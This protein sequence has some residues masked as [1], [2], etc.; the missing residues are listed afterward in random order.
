MGSDAPA[1]SSAAI[2]TRRVLR[3]LAAGASVEIAPHR[4]P[5]ADVLARRLPRG[6][7]V[8]VPFLP[9][10]RWR[11]TTAAC[12]LLLAAGMRPVP[13]LPTRMVSGP[14]ALATWLSELAET[15]VDSLMLVAGD[16]ATPA[17]PYHDTLALLDSGLLAR[18]GFTRLGVTAHPEGHP[19]VPQT[20]LDEALRRK[21]EY[22]ARTGTEMWVVTQFVFSAAPALA[23]LAR[24]RDTG[25]ALPVRV[26]MAGPARVPALVG[27][28][29]R[30]G[31]GASLRTLRG[32][33]G[34]ARLMGRWSPGGVARELARHLARDRDT[35][36]AGIHLFTFGGLPETSEWLRRMRL[37]DGGDSSRTHD[38]P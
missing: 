13:H 5:P 1:P 6:T 20:E 21:A 25:C 23:W 34:T 30:C 14:D 33:P 16:R 36:L 8:Y 10:G 24:M 15:G 2:R 29:I 17:G 38:E 26:G 19:F 37:A 28:A 3:G 27:Y 4:V 11:E 22:A 7:R 35:P 9:K 31:V 18:H 12:E 32:R